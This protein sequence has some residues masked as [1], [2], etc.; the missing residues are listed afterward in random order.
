MRED[1]TEPTHQGRRCF[2]KT[3]MQTFVATL[4]LAKQ[5]LLQVA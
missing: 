2:G 4:K 3:P 1:N 5:K